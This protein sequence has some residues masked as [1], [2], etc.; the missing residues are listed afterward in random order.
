MALQIQPLPL[1]GLPLSRFTRRGRKGYLLLLCVAEQYRGAVEPCET[2][3]LKKSTRLFITF[4]PIFRNL[5][6]AMAIWYFVEPQALWLYGFNPFPLRDF[7]YLV[8]LAGAEK[9]AL[10]LI[11]CL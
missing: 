5:I 9:V 7:P 4:T 10:R 3:G 11:L 8:S 2:E 1:A 6:R